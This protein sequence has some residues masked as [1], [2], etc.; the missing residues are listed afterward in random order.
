MITVKEISKEKA[1]SAASLDTLEKLLVMIK[2]TQ[3]H[4]LE[5]LNET[6]YRSDKCRTPF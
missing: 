4:L 2:L 1:V 6:T 5:R 3:P